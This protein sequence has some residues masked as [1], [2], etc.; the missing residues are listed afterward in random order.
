M[1]LFLAALR[2]IRMSSRMVT[3][4]EPNAMDPRESVEARTKEL[5]VGC[6]GWVKCKFH[7]LLGP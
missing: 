6:L 7:N 2:I 5:S 4:K 3:I 1:A